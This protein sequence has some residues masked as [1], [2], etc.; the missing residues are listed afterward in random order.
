[1]ADSTSADPAYI[2]AARW[3]VFSRIY[4]PVLA[5]T[6]RE[7]RFRAAMRERVS[8]A[9]PEGGTVVDVGCGTGT[10]LL[11]MAAA[12]P[13][14]TLIGVDG[15][16]EI[17]ARARAKAGAE[18]VEWRDGLAGELPLPDDSADVMTMSLVLHHLLPGQ[19]R[20]AMRD[21]G[22]VLKPGGSFQIA[23]WGP[24]HDP[25]MSAVFFV[26]QAIDGFERTADHRAGRLPQMLREAG[27]EDVERYGRLRTAGGSLDLL[28]AQRRA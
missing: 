21:I 11:G 17:L 6:M 27:F 7:R 5:L 22:R 16:P 1:M 24:P 8:A 15:D 14:A 13:D 2:P 3:R 26:S 12:R 25:A 18:A 19:K 10:F 9:L 28:S 23:D 20:E 4:D